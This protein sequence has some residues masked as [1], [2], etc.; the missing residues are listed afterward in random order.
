MAFECNLEPR[1]KMLRFVMGVI[2]FADG[3]LLG[4]LWA[5]R[6]GSRTAWI[7]CVIM[8]IAGAYMMWAGKRGWCACRALGIKTPI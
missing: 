2:F 3:M 5:W 6:T 8:V 1:G 4:L 7:T